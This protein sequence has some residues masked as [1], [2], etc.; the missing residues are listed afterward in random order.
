MLSQLFIKN[1]AVIKQA[2][3]RLGSGLNV[4]TGETGA[5]KSVLIGAISGVLGGRVSKDLI[6][7]G[8]SKAQI[9]AV[10]TEL[11][12]AVYERL[13]SLGYE[14]E[15][16]EELLI[17]REVSQSGTSCRINGSPATVAILKQL[18]ETLVSIHGQHDNQV[19]F[20]I[21][22]HR[23][24][25]DGYAQLAE[26]LEQ[27]KAAYDRYCQLEQKLKE[28]DLDERSRNER[29][30]LLS[31]QTR[32]LEEAALRE[33]EEEALMAR[34]ATISN[35]SKLTR[36]LGDGLEKLTGGEASGIDELVSDL[37]YDLEQ[38]EEY[39]PHLSS[40]RETVENFGYELREI[41]SAMRSAFD[42]L[43]FDPS[44]LD[45]LESRLD[46]IYRLKKKYGRTEAQLIAYYED[47]MEE[48]DSIT[49]S[50]E[51]L[52]KMREERTKAYEVAVFE[53]AK[54]TQMRKDAAATL[55]KE[56]G[57][58]LADLDMLSVS[59]CA[60]FQSKELSSNGADRIE[61]LIATNRGEE[62]KPMAK[63]ASGGELSRI[64]LALKNITNKGEG[65]ATA[66]FDE[67]DSGVSGRAAQ[68]IGRKLQQVAS[69]QQ[70]ICVT[71]LSQV[72]SFGDQHLLICKS[73][74]GE[75]TLTTIEPL[76]DEG[77]VRE[78]AR[79]NSGEN[80]TELALSTAEE[81]LNLHKRGEL[82][83]CH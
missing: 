33:G 16:G 45:D 74:E 38:L 13:S 50:E 79:I 34:R 32:E 47:A 73:V 35:I 46:L 52:E 2:E 36:L 40:A 70:I 58:Q 57:E 63:I 21:E 29:I 77:R 17:S 51:R 41:V 43:E 62:A 8:E 11:E 65:V 28:M 75:R 27:Y 53:A 26:Q 1:L 12:P 10:F 24:I 67:V 66:I 20:N 48:L 25:I 14:T 56:L 23:K 30:D 61:F 18:G 69:E 64:M 83:E 39:M 80:I 76:D 19:L 37:Q 59:I 3:I 44:E 22:S 68:K 72:A 54:L 71:H 31:F 6:R 42:D 55:C 82:H 7:S 78:I 60:D 49:F 15:E 4:F 9:S 81:M 5:G